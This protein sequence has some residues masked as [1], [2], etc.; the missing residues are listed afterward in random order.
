MQQT[1][2]HV[3]MAVYRTNPESKGNVGLKFIESLIKNKFSMYLTDS[4]GK[5][6]MGYLMV[7][8]ISEAAICAVV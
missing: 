5:T 7:S 1:L 4:E 2:L 8:S 6:P 3:A